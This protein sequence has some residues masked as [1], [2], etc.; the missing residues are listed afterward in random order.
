MNQFKKDCQKIFDLIAKNEVIIIHR[1][2]NPDGDAL[3]SQWGLKTIIQDNFP[4][5]KVLVPGEMNAHMSSFFP[6]PDMLQ[7]Q[8]YQEALVIVCDTAN[9]E[10]ISGEN[11]KLAT[12][13]IKI[14]HHPEIDSYGT[15][16]LINE[17]ASATCQIIGKWAQEM[18]LKISSIAARHLFLG[19][20][21]DSGR[22]LYRSVSAE[23]FEVASI[24]TATKFNLLDLYEELYSQDIKMARI[25]GYI[26]TN[27]KTT[28]NGVG[29]IIFNED[30]LNKLEKMVNKDK[31][32]KSKPI[33]LIREDITSQVNLMSNLAGVKIWMIACQDGNQP[34][35]KVSVR[36]ARWSINQIVAKF[37]GG[38][39]QTAAGGRLSNEITVKKLLQA[40]DKTAKLK[41]T[42]INN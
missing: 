26:L 20:V 17:T 23:T 29:Y 10:R 1:H 9:R 7:P 39:H 16:A 34:E 32:L 42:L 33:T 19:L 35:F 13:V 28:I 12:N 4:N 24:L 25:R 31:T 27:F 37:G 11:W 15:Y 6:E 38:G 40:L 14:D 41:P 3:G 2:V 18:N 22:F 8:D 5:K 36:S 21:T 30:K